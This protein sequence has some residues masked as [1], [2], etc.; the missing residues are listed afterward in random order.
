MKRI[1]NTGTSSGLGDAPVMRFDGQ[2]SEADHLAAMRSRFP[3]DTGKAT[4]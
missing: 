2:T 1:L 4:R 3:T